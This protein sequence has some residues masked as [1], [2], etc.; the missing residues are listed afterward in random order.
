MVEPLGTQVE[1]SCVVNSTFRTT[2]NILLGM[3][4]DITTETQ[5]NIDLLTA[6]RG[7]VT[8]VSS[9]ENREPP[10][11]INGTIESNGTTVQCIAINLIGIMR[12]P[13]RNFLLTFFGKGH[14]MPCNFNPLLIM[15]IR[16]SFGTRKSDSNCQWTGVSTDILV[17][18]QCTQCISGFCGNRHQCH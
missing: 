9:A 15:L 18:G 5:S 10:L 12:C 6:D 8:N 13:G 1:V 7:I 3:G 4:S 11:R 16:S 17:S 14:F 2:W